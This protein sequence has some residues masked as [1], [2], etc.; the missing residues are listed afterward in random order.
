[1][2]GPS[3]VAYFDNAKL[4]L[5]DLTSDGREKY[6]KSDIHC[7]THLN[8]G[9]SSFSDDVSYLR[10]SLTQFIGNNFSLHA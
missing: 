1:M 7:L 3:I 9:V 8:D 2:E 6:Y 4:F 10:V 5:L